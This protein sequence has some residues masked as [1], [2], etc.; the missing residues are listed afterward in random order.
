[1]N[2]RSGSILSATIIAILAIFL[3]SAI[4]D[5]EA[6]FLSWSEPA[7]TSLSA[8]EPA[9]F[10]LVTD[11][12][13]PILKLSVTSDSSLQL[14]ADGKKYYVN[15]EE[16]GCTVGNDKITCIIVISATSGRTEIRLA[17]NY[18]SEIDIDAK[19]VKYKHLTTLSNLNASDALWLVG[20]ILVFVLANYY[21]YNHKKVYSEWISLVAA[22]AFVLYL[23]PAF[24]LGFL[25][26][27]ATIYLTR[28]HLASQNAR[29]YKLFI[30]ILTA[31]G[32][33]LLFKYGQQ[34]IYGIFANPGGF[35]LLLPLGVSYFVIRIIDTQLRWY[36]G[37][38]V[39]IGVRQFLLFVVFP[40]TLV[41]GPIE[42]L[43]D[44]YGNRLGRI[45]AVDLQYGVVRVTVGILKKI[46]IADILV[47]GALFG[48]VAP[49]IFWPGEVGSVLDVI[50]D[51]D[52]AT[53]RDVLAMG[54]LAALFAY[55]DFSSYSDIA[56]GFSRLLGYKITENFNY[57]FLAHNIR[58]YW[59]RWHMS[60]SSW[61]FRNI[62]FPML[63]KTHN[64]YIPLYITMLT[65]GMWHAFS[66][67]WFSWAI[68]HAT[69]M[70]VVALFQRKFPVPAD[71]HKYLMPFGVA[72]TLF[73]V[74]AGFVFVFL[75]DYS[76]SSQL[77]L[78]LISFGVLG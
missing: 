74:S 44:F 50:A 54:F 69:G 17:S 12:V 27:I 32:F 35:N 51:P 11:G 58:E 7:P 68:H 45:A 6:E 55:V 21:L 67:T 77:Y 48:T 46:V 16:P 33:L 63:L 57:P 78:K 10:S 70:S 13:I 42:N 29:H 4:V 43:K 25:L 40:G 59:K 39:D 19:V 64:Q 65:I 53:V 8:Y 56:I 66:L 62:Y 38:L 76:L 3:V 73:F 18:N 28:T 49:D 36:R 47:R 15:G 72:L 24:F 20:F 2:W 23:S 41:A 9:V 75:S 37:E 1:V 5:K 71:Y 26:F 31:V 14:V 60:L 61:S 52:A 34:A 22:L 30:A